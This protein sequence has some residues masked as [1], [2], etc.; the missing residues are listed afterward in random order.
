MKRALA[1]R[2]SSPGSSGGGSGEKRARGDA[3]GAAASPLHSGR[4]AAGA[5]SNGNQY[6]G[7]RVGGKM[8][9]NGR[10]SFSNGDTY[11]GDFV[12][13]QPVLARA[14]LR[15]KKFTMPVIAC[16]QLP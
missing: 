15:A 12:A 14:L 6:V 7:E 5:T 2:A 3:A 9:G 11:D 16:F 8:E 10:F 13:D 4:A 1:S